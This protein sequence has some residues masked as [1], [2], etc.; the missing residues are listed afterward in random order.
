[1]KLEQLDLV[2]V[3]FEDEGAKA[4]LVFLDEDRGEIREVN[5]NTKIYDTD[6]KVFV[7]DGDKILKVEEWCD[8]YFGLTYD[9]LAQAIGTKHDV[10]AYDRFNSL[11]ES[12]VVSKFDDDMEGQIFEAEISDIIVDNVGIKIR[13]KYE[14]KTYN[15][16]MTYSDYMENLNKWFVNPQK[17]L[18][19]EEKFKQKFHVPVEEAD[20]LV[21]IKIMVEVRKAM[22][23]YIWND[24]KPLPKKK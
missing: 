14:G 18:K 6:K 11:W 16:N 1:M 23:K 17:K 19:Q 20:S 2:D 8:E 7:P 3:R 21:G 24:I 12:D 13:F 4:V 22:G 15:T 10:Y 5:F 9:T